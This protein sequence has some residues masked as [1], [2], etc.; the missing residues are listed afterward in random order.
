MDEKTH[1]LLLEKTRESILARSVQNLREELAEERLEKLRKD[2]ADLKLEKVMQVVDK[3]MEGSGHD[4]NALAVLDDAISQL[5]S[6]MARSKSYTDA[7]M[8]ALYECAYLQE[9][10]LHRM[11][12]MSRPAPRVHCSGIRHS[13][14]LFKSDKL[15]LVTFLSRLP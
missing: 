5:C 10:V 6:D 9:V 11:W 7:T 4:M 8:N 3:L 13:I 12:P 15:D 1:A 14:E 2:T